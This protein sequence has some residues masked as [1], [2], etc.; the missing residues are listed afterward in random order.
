MQMEELT[1]IAKSFR[2]AFETVGRSFNFGF[3]PY[4]PEGCCTWASIFIGNFLK[5]EHNL[6]A[7]RVFSK[8][9]HEWTFVNNYIVDITADQFC[10]S[11]SSVIVEK[12]SK[13]HSQL[14]ILE[15]DD[16]FPVSQYDMSHEKYKVSDIYKT[17][18]FKVLETLGTDPL[19]D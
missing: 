5:E 1:R 10:N 13:W 18:K 9:N 2:E 6:Q 3:F 4:F 8:S 11:I 19:H 16:Y 15:I 7:K 14:G 17:I 12:E